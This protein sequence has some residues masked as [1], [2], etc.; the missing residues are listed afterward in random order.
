MTPSDL[1]VKLV[2]LSDVTRRKAGLV[3]PRVH[4]MCYRGYSSDGTSVA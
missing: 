1:G 4:F 2:L 3:R